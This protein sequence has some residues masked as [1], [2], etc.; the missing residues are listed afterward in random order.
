MKENEIVLPVEG[1]T[2]SSCE[3]NVERALR[4]VEGVTHVSVNLVTKN[5]NVKINK[6]E[7]EIKHL[8]DAV[9]GIG[10][11]I[12]TENATLLIGGMTCFDCVIRVDDALSRIPGVI[13]VNVSL[14]A[15]KARV[16][17]VPGVTSLENFEQALM[18]TGKQLLGVVGERS[19]TGLPLAL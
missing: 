16:S 10:Y 3:R 2:C 18:H 17:Y 13:N 1:M 14:A 11:Q 19:K 7:V 8:V 9:Q 4:Q 12:S 6:A 5:A 15:E